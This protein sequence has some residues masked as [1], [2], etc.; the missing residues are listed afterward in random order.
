MKPYEQFQEKLDNGF[1]E[2]MGDRQFLK[3]YKNYIIQQAFFNLGFSENTILSDNEFNLFKRELNSVIHLYSKLPNF[4]GRDDEEKDEDTL[5]DPSYA[6][7]QNQK[8][9]THARNILRHIMRGS[10][11]VEKENA[12]YKTSKLFASEV[13]DSLFKKRNPAFMQA[14]RFEMQNMFH[15]AFDT[16]QSNELSEDSQRQYEIFQSHALAAYTFVDPVP[17]GA[18]QIPQKINKKWQ[19]VT[20]NITRLD[21]SPQTGLLA[22]TIDDTD[23]IY[24]YGLTAKTNAPSLLLLMGTTYSAGQGAQLAQIYN[25][26]PNH[27]VGEGHDTKA[28][29]NWIS[30]EHAKGKIIHATGHSKGATMAMIMTARHAD[31]I[32]RADCLNPTGLHSSTFNKLSPSWDK[33]P[34]YL[35]PCIN[36][37]A[38]LGDPVFPLE[39]GFLTGTH[40]YKMIPN[41]Q[42]AAM[43]C[44]TLLPIPLML[45]KLYEAHIHH[46]AGR[47]EILV[48]NVNTEQENQRKLRIFLDD[49]KN[50]I[51][52]TRFPVEYL[53][54]LTSTL[55]KKPN[56]LYQQNRVA[57]VETLA[58]FGILLCYANDV[59]FGKMLG[60]TTGLAALP[61]LSGTLSNIVF[62]FSKLAATATGAAVG[63]LFSGAKLSLQALIKHDTQVQAGNKL[64]LIMVNGERQSC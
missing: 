12:S 49:I 14:L 45:R 55:T 29:D 48:L 37:Y 5:E 51:N 9:N 21:I 46:F 13:I 58:L 8:L 43:N 26:Y 56:E 1:T 54:I 27:S 28:V 17:N 42:N 15:R 40:I 36:V 24:A 60:L 63:G 47:N 16:L 59:S 30:Q 62:G 31:K 2:W 52:W 20:Y 19:L 23:R 61:Q 11:L 10:T 32:I 50:A 6:M 7:S 35:K 38:Q 33:I 22:K 53:E 41:T 3:P 39:K 25:F 34:D 64:R 57:V 18:L 4:I 44:N